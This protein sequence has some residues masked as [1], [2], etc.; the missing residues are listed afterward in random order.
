MTMTAGMIVVNLTTV[1][2]VLEVRGDELVLKAWMGTKA[3]GGKWLAPVAN[4][5]PATP[6]EI[7]K[8]WIVS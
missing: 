4:C 1:A 6:E 7:A 8:P 5:R 3:K 2:K